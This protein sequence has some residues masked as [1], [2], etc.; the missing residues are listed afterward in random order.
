MCV[1]PIFI[2]RTILPC[3]VP[4]CGFLALLIDSIKP[5]RARSLVIAIVTMFAFIS[6]SGYLRREA[7]KPREPWRDVATL[8]STS[9]RPILVSPRWAM[10]T[11]T[12]YM[13]GLSHQ[14]FS[15]EE[16]SEERL[17]S[18]L[19]GEGIS[20]ITYTQP[21]TEAALTPSPLSNTEQKVLFQ[22]G[23][24]QVKNVRKN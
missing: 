9:S 22:R 13:N 3:I 5:E 20:L 10:G 16:I 15:L 12:Y 11:V 21:G 7:Y 23:P 6:G 2:S 19:A 18:L 4:L 8:L 24:I 1:T 14:I 17:H